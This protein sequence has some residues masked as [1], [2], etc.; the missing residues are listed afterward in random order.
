MPKITEFKGIRYNSK[1]ISNYI[2]PPYDV[3]SQSQKNE[4]LGKSI[5][6]A[7]KIELPENYSSA[8]ENFD[9]WKREECLLK[10]K[11]P[12][13]Y[14]YE[15]SFIYKGKRY[16]RTGFF[17]LLK[18]E[19]LGKSIFPHE[20]THKGPKIDRLNLLKT[21]KINTSPIFC[22][23]SDKKNVF[24]NISKKIKARVPTSVAILQETTEKVWAITDT[25]IINTLK[26]LLDN[27]KILIADGHHRYETFYKFTN[28]GYILTFLCPFS[29]KG[30]LILPTHR[31]L[32]NITEKE[33]K[34]ILRFFKVNKN[35]DFRFYTCK[36]FIDVKTPIKHSGLPIE[37]LHSTLLKNKEVNYTKDEKEAIEKVNKGEFSAAIILKSLSIKD[38]EYVVKKKILLPQKSTYFYPKVSTGIVFNELD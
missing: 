6:N 37:Y 29:D 1:D 21:T 28:G 34:D 20:K 30:L 26:K 10:E 23:F 33:I 31:L 4:L 18:T 13:F 17:A 25:T 8:K 27:N 35:W 12:S 16:I 9:K 11:L 2:C 15:Q 36:C 32:K 38:L 3:I 24:G 19:K 14:L 5:Y 22:L 7:V